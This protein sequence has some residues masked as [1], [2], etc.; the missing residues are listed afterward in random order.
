MGNGGS[1]I[2]SELF[3]TRQRTKDKVQI[4]GWPQPLKIRN[5]LLLKCG[6][7]I[8]KMKYLLFT[9]QKHQRQLY[10]K[11]P[12]PISIMCLIFLVNKSPEKIKKYVCLCAD[13]ESDSNA[14]EA[15]RSI[16]SD[17]MGLC[18]TPLVFR[19][20]SHVFNKGANY[21]HLGCFF[22]VNFCP[23]E[24]QTYRCFIYS[25]KPLK[26]FS[27]A[28]AFISYISVTTSF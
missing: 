11:I 16:L 6:N 21:R 14:T 9:K 23:L 20:P 4:L 25:H 18:I 8:K 5:A 3:K 26:T 19:L 28:A 2:A 13:I 17:F 27:E 7:Q 12:H 15:T 1:P 10:Y 22:N 24:P